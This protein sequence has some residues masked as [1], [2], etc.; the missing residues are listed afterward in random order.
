M[1]SIEYVWHNVRH[2]NMSLGIGI[3]SLFGIFS[4]GSHITRH[5]VASKKTDI[6]LKHTLPTL[7][8]SHSL[9]LS[10][11]LSLTHTHTQN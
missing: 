1:S 3:K 9:S 8:L 5:N 2:I 11:S 10:L 4:I 6:A 7:S